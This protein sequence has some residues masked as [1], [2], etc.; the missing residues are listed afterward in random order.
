MKG[1]L[2][3]E[4]RTTKLIKEADALLDIKVDFPEGM[5]A[6][7]KHI[8]DLKS[9]LT[10]IV[11]KKIT[12]TDNPEKRDRLERTQFQIIDKL[13]NLNITYTPSKLRTPSPRKTPRV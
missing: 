4:D 5:S 9:I 12:K 6:S 11:A 2:F 8:D 1:G 7:K 13:K 10:K 3:R